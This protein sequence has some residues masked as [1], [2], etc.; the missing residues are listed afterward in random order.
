MH[1]RLDLTLVDSAVPA[2][3]AD[4][5]ASFTFMAAADIAALTP[6]AIRHRAPAPGANDAET[7][8]CVHVDFTDPDLPWRYTPER[9]T[10]QGVRPW[11]VLLV[12]SPAEASV[13]GVKG[14]FSA[15]LLKDYPLATSW[16]WAHQQ[17]HGGHTVSRLLSLRPLAGQTQ[18]VAALVPAF[19]AAGEDQ[20]SGASDRV[21][22][23][24]HSWRFTTGEEGDFE[25]L[26]AALRLPPA[27]DIGKATLLYRRAGKDFGAPLEVRGALTS[28]QQQETPA[29]EQITKI[30]ADLLDLTAALS[31]LAGPKVLGLPHYGRPW[32]PEPGLEP[33]GWPAELNDDPRHRAVAGLG[34]WMGVEGQDS[35]MRAAVEQAGALHEAA[36][37]VNQLATGLWA[38][39]SLWNRA[40]PTAKADRLRLL[41]PMTA[42]LL[43]DGT[44]E[45]SSVLTTLTGPSTFLDA[46]L[47][48]SA[49][50]RLQR[51]GALSKALAGGALDHGAVLAAINQG[52]QR[53]KEHPESL[54]SAATEV[55]GQRWAE[56]AFGLDLD[57]LEDVLATL[58]GLAAVASGE[59]LQRRRE[60]L[61][62]GAA[63]QLAELLQ[64]AA[65]DLAHQL[66]ETLQ[67]ALAALQAPCEGFELLE[68]AGAAVGGGAVHFA[69]GLLERQQV[70]EL[71]Y[72]ILQP[73]MLRCIGRRQC[74][75]L[76][77]H[78]HEFR[79][80]LCEDV[81][82]GLGID[83]PA[84]ARPLDLDRLSDALFEALDPR[85]PD[86][87]ARRR[88]GDRLVGVDL[89]S[90][91]PVQ[92]PL[93]L[94]YPTWSLLRQYDRHWLLPGAENLAKNSITAL[95]T[96]PRFMDAYMVGIN[97]AFL[98]ETR[99]R[100]L[101]I[102]RLCTPLRMFWGQVDY[103]SQRRRADIEPLLEWAAAPGEPLGS[104]AHQ[105]IK[106]AEPGAASAERL[107]IIFNSALFRR[108]PSTLVY[109]VKPPPGD[110]DPALK[111]TPELDMPAN[112][113]GGTEAWRRNRQYFGPAFTG[114]L[115][116]DLVFFT[117][118]VAPATLADYWLVLDEPP[119][120]LRFRIPVNPLNAS[121]SAALAAMLLDE[122]TRV[123]IS[124]AELLSMAAE[125][126]P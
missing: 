2:Q 21:L 46:A 90:L 74:R 68:Q 126:E 40:M 14:T 27:A 25:T 47:F 48:S 79:A 30:R 95:Q 33:S 39:T 49:A 118:D 18:Y 106:P 109:L 63:E 121:H 36:A 91:A 9:I 34:L 117:F 113:P 16:L 23:V 58:A 52:P 83:A 73:L 70:D 31:Q 42:R 45:T 4:G 17:D 64:E 96:N 60:L 75:E 65:S 119:A 10:A 92:F 7:T 62:A 85:Q 8:K 102:D 37:R 111:A 86:S 69:K 78:R 67:D 84:R 88:L 59:Y 6:A 114:T 28:L 76:G 108:Y 66:A 5:Q 41:G 54:T 125:D 53:P 124:G 24:L 72:G 81:L 20:W 82:G 80:T 1:G 56:D 122:P 51:P 22:P 55:L 43:T 35:L 77:G 38:A 50:Q 44:G 89:T 120:E 98:A 104:L 93:A 97:T 101:P 32:L 94:D 116:P 71:L 26:A 100:G 12:G 115:S 99:W 13:S 61:E 103:T 57:W 15:S 19:D 110:P 107:V 105:T 29:A 11:L 123:A 87:P 3:P 112:P